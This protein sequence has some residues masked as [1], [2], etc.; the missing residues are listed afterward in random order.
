MF[1]VTYGRSGS[2]LLQGVLNA[3]PGYLIRGENGGVLHDLFR[4]HQVITDRIEWMDA[5][6]ESSLDP[7]HPFY[8]LHAYPT[9]AALEG[10]RRLAVDTVLRPEPDTR[11][12]GFKEVRWN[13]RTCRSTRPTSRPSSLGRSSWSTPATSAT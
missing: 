2:T 11:V 12:T 7:T 4:Y 5:R 6:G 1:I 10:Q 8:G 9:Q 3:L 13:L